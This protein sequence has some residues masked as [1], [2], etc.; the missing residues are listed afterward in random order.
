MT[1]PRYH[2]TLGEDEDIRLP[3]DTD[4]CG[5]DV[6]DK[7]L[8]DMTGMLYKDAHLLMHEAEWWANTKE[9]CVGPAGVPPQGNN[10]STSISFAKYRNR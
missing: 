4:D 7:S 10:A 9:H 8:R 1:I 2:A 3:P 5:I 6:L